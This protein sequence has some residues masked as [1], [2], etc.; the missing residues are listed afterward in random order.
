VDPG[1]PER[2]LEELG[3]PWLSHA[4]ILDG[5]VAVATCADLHLLVAVDR[6]KQFLFVFDIRGFQALHPPAV[7]FLHR[8]DLDEVVVTNPY[9]ESDNDNDN[10][11][12]D[13]DGN[14]RTSSRRKKDKGT[15]AQW[16]FMKRRAEISLSFMDSSHGCLLIL[17][18]N[19]FPFEC[20]LLPGSSR[21][22]RQCRIVPSLSGGRE[23]RLPETLDRHGPDEAEVYHVQEDLWHKLQTLSTGRRRLFAMYCIGGELL[24]Q[25]IG[26]HELVIL[27]QGIASDL[28]TASL[29][30]PERIVDV[31]YQILDLHFTLNN[32][33]LLVNTSRVPEIIYMVHG[34]HGPEDGPEDGPPNGP[35]KANDGAAASEVLAYMHMCKRYSLHSGPFARWKQGWLTV[36]HPFQRRYARLGFSGVLVWESQPWTLLRNIGRVS[37]QDD[38]DL[39][40]SCEGCWLVTIN[41]DFV[42][43]QVCLS[44][45]VRLMATRAVVSMACMSYER[46]RWL[47][48]I[49]RQMHFLARTR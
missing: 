49:V 31:V 44:S 22:V 43:F 5:C 9:S 40:P 18:M 1:D 30:V 39:E 17:M 16:H 14:K 36:T 24:A 48:A 34:K 47:S 35:P 42:L 37:L 38:E 12:D 13:D 28:A 7:S 23:W 11:D 32:L 4:S 15:S 6:T 19:G 46:I 45:P 21:Q 41:N 27:R 10:N 25:Q 33:A 2:N 8:I 20:S 3:G 29:W 26:Y